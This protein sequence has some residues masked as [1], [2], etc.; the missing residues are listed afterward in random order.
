MGKGERGGEWRGREEG[1]MGLG[2]WRGKGRG[3]GSAG[4]S[5]RGGRAVVEGWGGKV[6]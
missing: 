3:I 2:K 1:V 5:G 6:K 4:E